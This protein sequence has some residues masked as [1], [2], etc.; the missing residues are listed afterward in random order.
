MATSDPLVGPRPLI[1][2]EYSH[3]MGNS[4]GNLAEY[5][6]AVRGTPGLA[7]GFIWD[8]V[9]QG[10]VKKAE[11]GEVRGGEKPCKFCKGSLPVLPEGLKY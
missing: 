3:S 10:L 9:D 4:T 7:G 2:C 11:N 8:W 5:W 6:A 1:L